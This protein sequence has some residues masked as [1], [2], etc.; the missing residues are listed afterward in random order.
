MERLYETYE[1]YYIFFSIC[2]VFATTQ[3]M[4]ATK[5]VKTVIIRAEG[6]VPGQRSISYSRQIVGD[7][8]RMYVTYFPI[9]NSYR[10]QDEY[11]AQADEESEPRQDVPMEQQVAQSLYEE[12]GELYDEQEMGNI[13]SRSKRERI[14]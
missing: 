4:E 9:T 1:L 14:K 3:T 2:V 13:A 7:P 8:M 6:T 10:V 5:R 12:F 11:I